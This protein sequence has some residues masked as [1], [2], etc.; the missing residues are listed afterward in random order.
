ML[1]NSLSYSG[2]NDVA[3]FVCVI[4][5]GSFTAAAEKFD[6]SKSVVSKYITLNKD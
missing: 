6:T 4:Q 3:A 2:L 1:T 5:A